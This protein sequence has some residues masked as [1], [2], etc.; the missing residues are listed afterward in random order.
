MTAPLYLPT[1]ELVTAAW[2]RLAVPGVR[3]GSDLPAVDAAL[4]T[5]GA[6]RLGVVLGGS[7]RYVPM[8][9]PDVTAECWV[10]PDAASQVTPW[11]IAAQLAQ[12]VW[13]AT[14]D[15]ALQ[16]VVI[17]LSGFGSYGSARVHD[18]IAIR[19][20]D[21]NDSDPDDWARFDVDL[22]FTWTEL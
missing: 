14:F 21:R 11:L 13:K 6:I 15:P 8:N 19:G 7:D 17:D 16:G 12:R 22:A 18:V 9:T 5:D 10:P 3:V 2:L 4:R 20:P 1:T